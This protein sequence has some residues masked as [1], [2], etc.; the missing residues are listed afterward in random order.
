MKILLRLEEFILLIGSIYLFSLLPYQWWVFPV[1]ILVPDLSMIG[2]LINFK[3]GAY[4]YNIF[5]TRIIGVAAVLIGTYFEI[6][7]LTLAGVILFSH[8]AM[9]RMFNYGLKYQDSFKH[10]HLGKLD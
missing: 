6:N 1:F 4:F 8:T 3:T 2:Y 7:L 10:T 5:H 9:D